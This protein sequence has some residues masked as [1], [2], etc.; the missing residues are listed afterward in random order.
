MRPGLIHPGNTVSRAARRSPSSCFNEAR[1]DS[2]GKLGRVSIA[3]IDRF[4]ASMRPGL[5]HPGN[6]ILTSCQAGEVQMLQ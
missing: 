1:A 2:P 3:I 6:S 4:V 5:I